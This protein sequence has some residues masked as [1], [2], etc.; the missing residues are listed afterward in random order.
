MD[1]K[2]YQKMLNEVKD[3]NSHYENL[4]ESDGLSENEEDKAII[5]EA[6]FENAFLF[7]Q[8]SK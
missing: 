5:K 2:R 8:F 3:L 4:M 7:L 1:E 6:Y